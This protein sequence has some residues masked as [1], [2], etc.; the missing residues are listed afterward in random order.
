MENTYLSGDRN[1]KAQRDVNMVQKLLFGEN[2]GMLSQA[3]R[4][5][6]VDFMV[7]K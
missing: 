4:K 3:Y 1:D 6:R 5:N 7:N 2:A